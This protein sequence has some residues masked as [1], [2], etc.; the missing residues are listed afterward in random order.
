MP[1]PT[2]SPTPAISSTA[3]T[4]PT[5]ISAPTVSSTATTF[6]RHISAPTTAPGPVPF[7]APAVIPVPAFPPTSTSTFAHA[8]TDPRTQAVPLAPLLFA[9]ITFGIV[10]SL[11]TRSLLPALLALAVVF[12]IRSRIARAKA[13]EAEAAQRSAVVELCSALRSELQAGRQPSSAFAEAIWCRPELSDLAQAFST[14]EP[15]RSPADLLTAAAHIPGR[16]GLASLAACWRAAETYGVSLTGAVSG[17]EDGLRAEQSRRE[18]LATELASARSTIA[19]LGVLPVFGLAVGAALGADPI[20]TL[21]VRPAGQVCLIVGCLLELAGLNWT[22]WLTRS[23][24]SAPT[25]SST[26]NQRAPISISSWNPQR[27]TS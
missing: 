3:T 13:R 17:I 9:A 25:A 18:H 4:F 22:D 15:Q 21:L 11:L 8:N 1:T 20:H 10:A 19:L 2:T 24:E 6:P 5:P 14:P 7:P 16:E 26:I 27:G 23:A 12:P